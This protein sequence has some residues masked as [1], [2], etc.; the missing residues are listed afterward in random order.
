MLIIGE[1]L[2]A[3]IPSVEQAVMTRNNNWIA[4]LAQQQVECGAQMLDV[5]AAGSDSQDEC[6]EMVWMV[7]V[8]QDTVRVPLVLDSSNPRVL[9]EAMGVYRGAR[10]ILSS[11]TLEPGR[12]ESTLSLAVRNHCGVVALCVGE[13]GVPIHPE[14]R[15]KAA[16]TLVDRAI[17]AGLTPE[18]LYLDPLVMTIAADYQSGTRLFS[19]LRLL[20]DRFPKVNTICGVG[21]IGFQMPQRRLLNRTGVAMLMALGLDAF[22]VD[23]RDRELMASLSAAA[24]LAGQDEWCRNYFKAFRAGKL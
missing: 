10:P 5:N 11:I 24:A 17:A 6:A 3:A 13:N 2:N 12:L 7:R 20:K 16:E 19:T 22:M 9:Q 4:A 1:S 18:D 15:L 8:V 21:N 23:V 14:E